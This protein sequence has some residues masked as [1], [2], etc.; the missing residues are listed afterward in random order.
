VL[1]RSIDIDSVSLEKFN[2]C[3]GTILEGD[4]NADCMINLRDLEIFA[5]NWLKTE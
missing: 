4:F 5:D 3:L 1:F 2:N